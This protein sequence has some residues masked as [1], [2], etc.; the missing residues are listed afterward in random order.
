VRAAYPGSHSDSDLGRSNYLDN[1]YQ[2]EEIAKQQIQGLNGH[3]VQLNAALQHAGYNSQQER[4]ALNK[5]HDHMKELQ[6]GFLQSEATMKFGVFG[7]RRLRK[8][9]KISSLLRIGGPTVKRGVQNLASANTG[10]DIAELAFPGIEENR[11]ELFLRKRGI[12]RWPCCSSRLAT[13]P[14]AVVRLGPGE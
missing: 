9:R 2:R 5:S 1:L 10:G 6:E 13:E 11:E 7:G 8:R 3:I 12:L 14:R 4:K